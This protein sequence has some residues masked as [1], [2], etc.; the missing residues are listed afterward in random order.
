MHYFASMRKATC[1]SHR[2]VTSDSRV[3]PRKEF[4]SF[5][6]CSLTLVAETSS[7]KPRQGKQ[8]SAQ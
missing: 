7:H 3:Y 6:R 4:F 5:D 2:V 8:T 1:V